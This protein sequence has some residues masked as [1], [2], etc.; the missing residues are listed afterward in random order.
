MAKPLFNNKQLGK[1]PRRYDQVSEESADNNDKLIVADLLQWMQVDPKGS[2][3]DLKDEP[4][5]VVEMVDVGMKLAGLDKILSISQVQDSVINANLK[6]GATKILYD[7]Y[8]GAKDLLSRRRVKTTL[9]I[10]GGI[11]V[12]VA[13]GVVLGTIVFPGI[14]SAIGGALG[15]A[16][17]GVGAGLGGGI[18]LGI[19]GGVIGSWFG[20]KIS[21][22]FFKE[23]RHYELS[24]KVTSKVKS[25]FGISGKTTQMMSAYLY[26]RRMAIKSPLCQRYYRMV[27]KNG[28]KQADPV[29]MEKLAYFFCQ[30]LKLLN[31]ELEADPGNE[32]LSEDRRAVLYI[33]RQLKNA[34]GLSQSTRNHIQDTLIAKKSELP[35]ARM[36]EN[37]IEAEEVS[38]APIVHQPMSQV[39]KRF[40]E[41]LRQSKLDIKEVEAEHHRPES[42]NHS[43]YQYHIKRHNKPDLPD[44]LFREVKISAN[45]YSAEVLVDKAAL[46]DENEEAVSEVLVAQARALYESSGNQYLKVVADKDD[47]LAVRLMAAAL[48]ANMLPELDETEYPMDTPQATEKRKI[49]LEQAYALADIE[50]PAQPKARVGFRVEF[51]PK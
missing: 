32:A 25:R 24:K 2:V 34:Q 28:I 45:Q 44:I 16:I 3:P 35:P 42:R 6:K 8:Y 29:A 21:K 43:Y 41:N 36:V 15:G 17:A 10:M 23:E 38:K 20:N 14:G 1:S 33:L 51:E 12:G 7:L 9:A 31:L 48:K 49:I 46:D 47:A 11:A 50:L 30:E 40:V 27:R 37:T 18:G 5:D 39:N 13:I 4:K 22:R 26:N 19:I